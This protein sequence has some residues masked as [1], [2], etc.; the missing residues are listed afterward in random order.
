LQKTEK[1]LDTG[2]SQISTFEEKLWAS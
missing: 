1:W 2:S